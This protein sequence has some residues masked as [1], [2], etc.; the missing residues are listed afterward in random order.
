MKAYLIRLTAA[1]ILGAVLRKM[2]PEGG[3]GRATRLGSGLLVIL[4]ALG[5]LGNMDP[6]GAAAHLAE[7]GFVGGYTDQSVQQISNELLE[8]LILDSVEA[9]ILDKAQEL[10]A[11]VTAEVEMVVQNGCPIPWRVRIQGQV[12]E[13]TRERLKQLI[14]DELGIP[15]ERQIW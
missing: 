6:A 15:E 11:E 13:Q 8:E 4:T 10:G 14:Q 12:P 5:P 2:A 3:A 1:A 9:Y 7:R